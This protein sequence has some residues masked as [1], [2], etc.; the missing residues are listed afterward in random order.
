MRSMR[1]LNGTGYALCGSW[2]AML[3]LE[4][5]VLLSQAQGEPYPY[6]C[7]GDLVRYVAIGGVIQV[8]WLFWIGVAVRQIARGVR[9]PLWIV[10]SLLSI[11]A[12]LCAG[13]TFYGR[14][15]DES[16]GV[17]GKAVPAW[18]HNAGPSW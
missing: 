6:L 17:L 12:A 8:L 13:P 11:V 5:W 15:I 14:A 1:I 4:I 7:K 18:E 9:A 16:S 3:S 10:M 2:M